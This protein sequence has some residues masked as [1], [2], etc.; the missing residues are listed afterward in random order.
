MIRR[1]LCVTLLVASALLIGAATVG[2]ED[3]VKT[4]EQ[5]EQTHEGP[6]ETVS[7]GEPIVE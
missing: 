4:V 5:T 2:C 1:V 7:P 3:N 6:V